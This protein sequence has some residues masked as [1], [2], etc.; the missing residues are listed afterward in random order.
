MTISDTKKTEFILVNLITD[1][2]TLFRSSNSKAVIQTKFI[3]SNSLIVSLSKSHL[4]KIDIL[5][6]VIWEV[7]PDYT[8]PI[9]RFEFS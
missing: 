4:F 8:D 2:R 3:D 7:D 6:N 1:E 9:I 5:G